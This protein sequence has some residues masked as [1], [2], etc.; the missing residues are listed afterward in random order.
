MN[1]Q[2]IQYF[3]GGFKD[4]FRL[5]A[6]LVASIYATLTAF[7]MHKPYALHGRSG[8]S[9]DSRDRLRRR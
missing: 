7:A 9:A 4:S 5:A 1:N 3:S 2:A 6:A 8:D